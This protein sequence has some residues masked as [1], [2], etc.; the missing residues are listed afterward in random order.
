[1][2]KRK[3]HNTS[4]HQCDYTGFPLKTTCCYMPTWPDGN[5][6]RDGK[7]V[8]RGSYANWE[9]VAAHAHMMLEQHTINFDQLRDIMDY[10]HEVT[11]STCLKVAPN[12]ECLSHFK[13][14]MTMEEFH[15]LCC[16]QDGPINCVKL[17]PT[18]EILDILVNPSINGSFEFAEYMH[19]PFQNLG[20]LHKPSYF[21]TIRKARGSRD[22]ELTVWYWPDKGLPFNTIASNTFKMQLHGDV[23]MTQHSKEPSFL[24]RERYISFTRTQFDDQFVKK[25]R[26]NMDAP[27]ISSAEYG[28]VKAEM[29]AS[30]DSYEDERKKEAVRPCD[31]SRVMNMPVAVKRK[32]SVM[33]PVPLFPVEA[34]A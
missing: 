8:K 3:L 18:G 7:M 34:K 33:P 5:G 25:R 24:P 17:T 23:I 2:G 15:K 6:T 4:F 22:K 13:G 16:A 27:S 10:I 11:G 26:K 28:K 19:K 1:M 29:Q 14:S 20:P 30:L 31:I 12:Y 32:S 21:H 9:S